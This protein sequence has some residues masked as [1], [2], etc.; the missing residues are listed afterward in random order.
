MDHSAERRKQLQCRIHPFGTLPEL[1]F[2]VICA[3][4]EGQWLMSKH[5]KRDTWETQGGHIEAGETSLEAAARELYE[6]SGV[7]DAE[8]HP[9]CDYCGYDDY[10]Y[11]NGA[12][13]LADIRSLGILPESEMQETALFSAM[14]K[15][16]TYPD[17]SP[18]LYAEAE[19]LCAKLGIR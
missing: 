18:K 6:E 14:P 7:Q 17:V 15:E 10:G 13:F 1:K 3:R 2:V 19:K 12:V 9:V 11:A 4:F 16:L 5:K 8:I